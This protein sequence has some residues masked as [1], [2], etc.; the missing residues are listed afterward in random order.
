MEGFIDAGEQQF[1]PWSQAWNT[2]IIMEFNFLRRQKNRMRHL[3][4]VPSTS[5]FRFSAHTTLHNLLYTIYSTRPTLLLLLYNPKM[6]LLF[7]CLVHAPCSQPFRTQQGLKL[8]SK[9]HHFVPVDSTKGTPP[10][11]KRTKKVFLCL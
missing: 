7:E 2:T 1:I 9:A 5:E 8:T 10:P 6:Y 3:V 4:E 11:R